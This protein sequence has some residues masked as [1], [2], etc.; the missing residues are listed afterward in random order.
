MERERGSSW[1]KAVVTAISVACVSCLAAVGPSEA[2]TPV[3]AGSEFQVNTYTTNDQEEASVAVASDGD[4]VVVWQSLYGSGLGDYFGSIQ[5]QRFAS[6]GTALGSEFQVNTYTTGYQYELSVATDSDGDFVVVWES[7][8]SSGTDTSLHSIQ[9]QRYASDGTVQGP[10]FQVNTYTTNHQ[11]DPSVAAEADGDFVVVWRSWRSP[12]PD[13]SY[14]I[15][16]QRYAS[17]GTAL[18]GQFQVNSYTLRNESEPS[19]A[20]DSDGDF[21]VAW[22]CLVSCDGSF[23]GVQGR[24]FASDGTPQGVEFQVNTYTTS[25]QFD[26]TVAADAD[27]DFVVVWTSSGSSGTDTSNDSIQG[28]RYASDGTAQGSEFQVNTYTTYAQRAPS[29]AADA[30]GDFVVVWFGNYGTDGSHFSIQGQRYT[31]DGMGQG[32]EFQIN[33][34]T[35]SFQTS[36]SVA[37]EAGGD[38]VVVWHSNGSSGTDASYT[39]V[40]GQRFVLPACSDGRDNDGDSLI[41]YPSDPGCYGPSDPNERRPRCGLGFEVAP[42][43]LGLIALRRLRRAH[44]WG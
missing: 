43:L 31:S 14:S 39:S 28:Q 2:Q 38:F 9:G 4:F 12:A 3:P 10:E 32:S 27:G 29:V 37:G 6:D 44:G 34:Y 26:P 22:K 18:G 17:D 33:T 41:D 21:V 16:G 11:R 24:R 30:D 40:Q 15:Q 36:P 13:T 42:V 35:T 25:S 8:G 23:F 5:G 1:T 19:V 20:T 7:V